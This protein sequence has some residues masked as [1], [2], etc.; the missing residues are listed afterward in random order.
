MLTAN[1]CAD[2]ER[3]NDAIFDAGDA[4]DAQQVAEARRLASA[5]TDA[6]EWGADEPLE[7]S[8]VAEALYE[9]QC[10]KPELIEALFYWAARQT[11]NAVVRAM[12]AEIAD[13]WADIKLGE[14]K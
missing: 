14:K 9:V 4:H 5:F 2:A 10:S 13:E 7:K 8:T 11:G 6:A 1:P 12:V 3:Y